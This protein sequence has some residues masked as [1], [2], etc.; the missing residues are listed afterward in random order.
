MAQSKYVRNKTYVDPNFYVPEYIED[1]GTLDE[2]TID[3]DGTMAAGTFG[4]N[5]VWYNEPI[6]VVSTGGVELQA[7]SSIT[8][9]TPQVLR[10][11][12]AGVHVIDLVIEVPD[13]PGVEAYNIRITKAS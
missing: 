9:I 12:A 3:S 11:N 8:V 10:V 5:E 4:S 1:F 13:L 2:E 6:D 7:P